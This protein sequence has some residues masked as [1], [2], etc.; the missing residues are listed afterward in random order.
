MGEAYEKLSQRACQIAVD[1]SAAA[2][3]AIVDGPLWPDQNM[4]FHFL[5]I[6]TER[7]SQRK[8]GFLA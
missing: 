5:T 6:Q 7:K 1:I 3:K 2:R 8:V 4:F